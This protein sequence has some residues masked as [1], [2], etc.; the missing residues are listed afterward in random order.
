[1]NVTPPFTDPAMRELFR[2][3]FRGTGRYYSGVTWEF[4]QPVRPLVPLYLDGRTTLAIDLHES[5]FA[6]GSRTVRETY[7]TTWALPDGSPAAITCDSYINAERGRS[8]EAA[9]HKDI[10]RQTY[11]PEDIARIDEAYATEVRRGSEPRYWEDVEVGEAIGHVVKGPLTV[12]DIVCFHMGYGIGI[13]NWGPLRFGWKMRHRMPNFYAEDEY[14]VPDVMQRLHWD[15]K[16]A[17]DLGLP[18]PYDYGQM[19]TCWLS[20]LLTNWVGDDGWL[21][22]LSNQMRDFNFIGDTTTCTGTVT[23][24]RVEGEHRVVDIELAATNQRGKVTAPGEATVILPSRE[25]GPVVLPRP[26]EEIVQRGHEMAQQ[27]RDAGLTEGK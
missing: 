2:G 22:R 19:R 23:A 16:R 20:H 7:R 5:S 10:Q 24:K 1:V 9:K 18:A 13:Y 27:A 4:Y 21:W 15:P 8:R 6:G 25:G 26:P 11:T 3:L 12:T 14:G 17:E